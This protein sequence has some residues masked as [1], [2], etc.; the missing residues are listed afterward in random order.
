MRHLSSLENDQKENRS[1]EFVEIPAE[2]PSENIT[3]PRSEITASTDSQE[4]YSAVPE[5]HIIETQPE[6]SNGENIQIDIQY[7]F[8]SMQILDIPIEHNQDVPQEQLL[9][10]INLENSDSVKPTSPTEVD[11]SSRYCTISA[12][13]TSCEAIIDEICQD[14]GLEHV[15][16]VEEGDLT[17]DRGSPLMVCFAS[18]SDNGM[19]IFLIASLLFLKIT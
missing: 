5:I 1:N 8:E 9:Q 14:E 11:S 10:Q 12:S 16:Y 7:D 2:N 4:S 6:T 17:D 13:P 19:C 18:P 3:A 15:L